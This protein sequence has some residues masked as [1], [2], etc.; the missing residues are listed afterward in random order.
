LQEW[1]ILRRP[2]YQGPTSFSTAL[3]EAAATRGIPYLSFTGQA[4]HYIQAAPN[5]LVTRALLQYACRLLG[6]RLDLSRLDEV[7][8]AFRARCDEVVAQ[9]A[10]LQTYVHQLEEQYDES[11]GRQG[12]VEVLP[13]APREALPEPVEFDTGAIMQELETFLRQQREEEGDP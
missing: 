12:P 6:V 4:P 3:Y 8:V 13:E 7:A 2:T 11:A 5:P 10:T 1:G 9:D